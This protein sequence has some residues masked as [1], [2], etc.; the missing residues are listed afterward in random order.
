MR[1]FF[2]DFLLLSD[3]AKELNQEI[4]ETIYYA[5]LNAS[6]DEAKKDGVYESYKGSPIQ[7]ENSNTI[8]GGLKMRI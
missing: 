8:C 7:K 5:A 2:W 6:V 3:K 4:F 1:L